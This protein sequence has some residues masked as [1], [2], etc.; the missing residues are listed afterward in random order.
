MA[1]TNGT[2]TSKDVPFPTS[3]DELCS[4]FSVEAT[5]L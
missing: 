2:L 4:Y 1:P 3:N 5:V